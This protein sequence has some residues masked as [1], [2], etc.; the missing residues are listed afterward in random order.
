MKKNLAKTTNKRISGVCGGIAKYFDLDPTI[1]RAIWAVLTV[2]SS[3][4]PGVILY[5][6]LALVMPKEDTP[7]AIEANN[8]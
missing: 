3:C 8:L 5:I 7:M 2:G 4:F 1:V 6:I